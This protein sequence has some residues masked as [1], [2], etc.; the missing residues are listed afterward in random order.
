MLCDPEITICI[1]S[2]TRPGLRD[3]ATHGAGADNTDHLQRCHMNIL[4][5]GSKIPAPTGGQDTYAMMFTP[6]STYIVSP[7]I[8]RAYGVAR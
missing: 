2:H 3:A 5:R 6:P 8:R 7:D 1:F 4:L